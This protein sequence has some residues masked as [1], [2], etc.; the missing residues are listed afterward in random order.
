MRSKIATLMLLVVMLFCLSQVAKG[1]QLNTV[2]FTL[3]Y[4]LIHG[5]FEFPEEAHPTDTIMCNLT[6]AADVNVTTLN[7]TVT[8]SG[9]VAGSWQTLHVEPITQ[10]LGQGQNLSR[11][12][13]IT[14][15]QN[16]SERL[17]YVID[18]ST[19]YGKGNTSFYATY[20]REN[21]YDELSNLY[22]TLLSNNSKLE[23]DYNQLL[24]NYSALN[25][26]YASVAAAYEDIQASYNSLNSSQELLN[27][28]YSSLNSSYTSLQDSYSYIKTKYDAS[29]W[30]LSI[31]RDLMYALGISTVVL[32]A[33]TIYLRKKAPYILLRKE[34]AVKPDNE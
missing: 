17:E 3:G 12:I 20:V 14:L 32:A 27:A 1:S 25:A 8:I 9:L 30:E 31:V 15:P 13:I 26:T 21:T 2:S 10:S 11:H 22:N 6:I 23:A 28:S 19:D 34:T 16:V 18:V 5:S 7:V 29:Q 33:A 4:G 24:T